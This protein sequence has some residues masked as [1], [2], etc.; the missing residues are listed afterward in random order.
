MELINS[1]DELKL[2]RGDDYII[3]DS[4]TIRQ[5]TLSEICEY[6]EKE[7]Y[8]MVYTLC[9]VGAD[10]KWQLDDL[11][12]DY[13][14]VS[15]FELFCS[16]L[17]RGFSVENTKILFGE[18]IDFSQ[19]TVRLHT[20]LQEN[21]LI[22]VFDDGSYLQIDKYVY[23]AIVNVLRKMHRIKRNNELPGNEAT[24]Q[25]LIEDARD[26]YEENKDRP[27]KPYLF[28]FISAMVNSEGFKH[29]EI[30]VFNMKIYAFMD[31]VART[32][33]IKNS[34]LLLSSGYSGFG[35]DLKKINKEETNWLGEL[36]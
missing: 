31:S 34:E 20:G 22:Q 11:G 2:Y 30:S 7:Y 24:R 29:D 36:D 16:V 23:A 6:G 21:V 12:V 33:K 8:S 4:I 9:S 35:I 32:S 26:S 10:L 3:N 25:I 15:D 18:K 17:C 14:Q 28:P 1:I 27:V 19:M 13:T 5:P